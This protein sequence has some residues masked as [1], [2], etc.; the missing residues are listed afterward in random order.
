MATTAKPFRLERRAPDSPAGAYQIEYDAENDILWIGRACSCLGDACI[1]AKGE[2]YR[3]TP[4]IV[5]TVSETAG[6]KR[7]VSSIALLNASS[8]TAWASLF[9]AMEWGLLSE[10]AFKLSTTI[11]WF[12]PEAFFGEIASAPESEP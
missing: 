11:E 7:T 6:G 5:Y 8:H 3:P 1:H 9:A 4:G 12:T 2:S 10:S